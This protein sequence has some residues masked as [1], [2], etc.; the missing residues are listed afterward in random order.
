MDDEW[1]KICLLIFGELVK[2][3]RPKRKNAFNV[4][5]PLAEYTGYAPDPVL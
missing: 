1:L 3:F 4:S 2:G 5:A